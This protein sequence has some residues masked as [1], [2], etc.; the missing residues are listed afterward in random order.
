MT[1]LLDW[2]TIDFSP[3]E[4]EMLEG[5]PILV[6]SGRSSFYTTI[7]PSDRAILRY[8]PGCFEAVDARGRAALKLIGDRLAGAV[9]QSHE[10]RVG[11]MLIIDNWRVLHG[12]GPSNHGSDRRLA[13]IL[14]NA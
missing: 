4:F 9:A 6:R 7:L 3:G 11:D 12:R 8:D 5:A 2:Q 10:W 14:I 13:R 1:L